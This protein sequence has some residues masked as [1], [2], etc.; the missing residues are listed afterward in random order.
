MSGSLMERAHGQKLPG[1]LQTWPLLQHMRLS[2]TAALLLLLLPE[3]SGAILDQ[4]VAKHGSD[5]RRINHRH[6]LLVDTGQC[7]D[8]LVE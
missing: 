8:G 2:L 7:P 4:P 5:R 3:M 6:R 1:H